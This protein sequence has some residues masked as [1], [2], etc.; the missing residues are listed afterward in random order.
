M[1]TRKINRKQTRRLR[2]KLRK[3]QR[4]G[5]LKAVGRCFGAKCKSTV[6]EGAQKPRGIVREQVNPLFRATAKEVN[7]ATAVNANMSGSEGNANMSGS[8]GNANMRRVRDNILKEREGLPYNPE[9]N[10]TFVMSKNPAF[11][12]ERKKRALKGLAKPNART[13][14]NWR[15]YEEAERILAA[16]AKAEK[17]E[18]NEFG[19]GT[20]VAGNLSSNAE[21]EWNAA[22]TGLAKPAGPVPAGWAAVTAKAKARAAVAA[23]L[24]PNN[25]EWAAP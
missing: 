24:A 12:K 22:G 9:L 15:N 16:R 25:E 5:F 11:E 8:E 13:P 19:A 2:R 7:A 21:K 6:N 14:N 18:W 1:A 17:R 3:T 23:P 4:A 20:G 10:T